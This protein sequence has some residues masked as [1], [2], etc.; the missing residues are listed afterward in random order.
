[1]KRPARI[2]GACDGIATIGY[3]QA[4]GFDGPFEQFYAKAEPLAIVELSGN[5]GQE[6]DCLPGPERGCK[7]VRCRRATV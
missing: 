4:G 1:L 2:S 3:I 6:L 7:T 5:V